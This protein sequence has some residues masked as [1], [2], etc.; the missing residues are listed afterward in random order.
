MALKSPQKGGKNRQC[1]CDSPQI[2][3]HTD[4]DTETQ[5]HQKMASN[6]LHAHPEKTRTETSMHKETQIYTQTQKDRPTHITE[7]LQRKR[8]INNN[9]KKDT[10]IITKVWKT[11]S[12][13]NV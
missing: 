4:R 9:L 8:Q 7:L 11:G 3:K 5:K 2:L 1:G 10:S 12:D 13:L 6:E